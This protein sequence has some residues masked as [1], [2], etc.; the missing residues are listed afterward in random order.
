MTISKK[1]LKANRE[2]AKKS[3][4]P[5]TSQGIDASTKHNQVHGLYTDK[6]VGRRS[7]NHR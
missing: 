1:Q 2:N 7:K 6:F 3:T 4:G 5:K